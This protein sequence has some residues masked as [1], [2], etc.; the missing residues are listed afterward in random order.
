[1][2]ARTGVPGA[3]SAPGFQI[4]AAS[5]SQASCRLITELAS[6]EK[7]GGPHLTLRWSLAD[8]VLWHRQR[9]EALI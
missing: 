8:Q 6:A 7:T 9:R 3:L 1:M 2:V 4:H 5:H